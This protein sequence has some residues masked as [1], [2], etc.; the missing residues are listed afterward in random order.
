[1]SLQLLSWS[2]GI[3]TVVNM[4]LAGNKNP[5][6]WRLG[7]GSQAVWLWFDWIVGAWGLMPLAIVLSVV[8]W[9][10]LRRWRR[11]DNGGL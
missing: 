11:P 10:N 8:Y 6:A 2:L 1:M 5:W 4:W 3:L 9:R 7:I